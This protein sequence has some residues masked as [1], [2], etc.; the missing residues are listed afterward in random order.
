MEY[1]Y[2]QNLYK[3]KPDPKIQLGKVLESLENFL[4]GSFQVGC[5]AKP[6]D[7]YPSGVINP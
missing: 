1:G 4:G 6:R 3:V 5:G 2:T 7:L